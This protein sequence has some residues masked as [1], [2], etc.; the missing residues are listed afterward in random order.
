MAN[1]LRKQNASSVLGLS[2]D[3]SRLEGVV[4]RRTNG[5]V[6]IQ[7]ALSVSLSLDPLTNDSELVGQ[8]IR[9]HL[10]KAGIRERRC[11]V[12]V[13]LNW[14]L[15]LQTALPDLAEAD[16]DGFLQLE[17]E[18]G[19]PYGPE[20]LLISTS[21]FE[22]VSGEK[23]A[24][25]VAIPRDHLLRLEKA[26]KAARLKPI[27][28]SLGITSSQNAV[29]ETSHGVMAIAV[30]ENGVALQ[31]SCGGGIAAL[32]ALEG[33]LETEGGLK[34]LH[35]DVVAREIRITLGQLPGELRDAV[36]QLRVFGSSDLAQQL[37]NDLR[38]RA[39][40][41]RMRVAHVTKYSA[42]EFGVQVS[43]EAGFSSA[44]SLAVR[45]LAGR[46][47]G[48]EFLPPKVSP[49]Q[50]FSA[51]HSSKK[52]VWAGV[53]AGAVAVLVIA[54][55][56]FQEWQLSQLNTKWKDMAPKVTELDDLQQQIRR[57]R[58][59]FD[60]SF[61][62]LTILRKVTEAFP[63]EGDVTA[64]S[65]EIRELSSVTCSGVARDNPAFLKMLDQLRATREIADLK[66]DNVRGSGRAPLQ[67]T[68]NFHWEAGG[69]N[70]H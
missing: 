62:N 53:S 18:R 31:V 69:A 43:P 33:T 12:C 70:E 23:Y 44:L 26:L 55:F 14:A 47:A 58:P 52:L 42:S 16:V 63:E 48:L 29:Q 25:Q 2:L 15:T 38:A 67:F 45:Y 30:G 21:R 13:P 11:A 17:A 65:L 41:L 54:A 51:R 8:E 19:F 64:K 24:T 7:K 56:I 20:A 50:Q 36:G 32:R 60:D 66:V 9:N 39:D 40:S 35:S 37:A 28:F 10:E 5:S 3:G 27:T 59:W 68:F 4:V 6:V 46:S 1:L 57:F 34:K 22:T 61:R 49:W